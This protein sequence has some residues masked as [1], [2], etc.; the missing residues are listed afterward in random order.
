VQ[1]A[2]WLGA[3]ITGVCSTKNVDMVRSIGA[4]Y[5]IDYVHE[6]FTQGKQIYDLIFDTIGNHSLSD[7]RRVLKPKGT[8][9]MVGGEIKG[10]WLG[11][12]LPMFMTI[13]KSFFISQTIAPFLATRSQ[14]DLI[15]LGELL[16]TGKV[17]PV[18]DRIYSLAEIPVAMRYLELGHARGKVI[19]A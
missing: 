11:P 17:T 9:V 16:E 14:K 1:I 5:V 7:Y 4:D 18:I 15:T 8:L 19:I 13:V 10:N 2:K 6:N 12:M 3:E